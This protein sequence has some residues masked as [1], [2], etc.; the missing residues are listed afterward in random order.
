MIF[1]F[2]DICYQS[3]SNKKVL[4]GLVADP[5]DEV[6]CDPKRKSVRPFSIEPL[7]ALE[8]SIGSDEMAIAVLINTASAPISIASEA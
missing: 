1:I 4:K 5:L 3:F 6:S 7:K 2:L 8:I